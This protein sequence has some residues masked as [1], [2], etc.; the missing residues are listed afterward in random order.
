MS[1]GDAWEWFVHPNLENLLRVDAELRRLSI[2]VVYVGGAVIGLYLDEFGASK[3]RPTKD[4]DC[5]VAI[6]G[7]AAYWRFESRLR[8]SGIYPSTDEGDPLPLLPFGV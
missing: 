5:I 2:D 7:R 1:W 8:A 3:V 4:V 6:E